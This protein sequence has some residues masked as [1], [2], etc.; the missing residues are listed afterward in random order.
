MSGATGT[1]GRCDPL[2]VRED[3]KGIMTA[4]AFHVPSD[5]PAAQAHRNAVLSGGQTDVADDQRAG[6]TAAATGVAIP[7]ATAAADQENLGCA[8]TRDDKPV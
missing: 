4:R 7:A 2:P 8:T 5:G 1:A 3:D 6:A